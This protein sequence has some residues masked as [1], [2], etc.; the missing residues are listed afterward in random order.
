MVF[1]PLFVLGP[2]AQVLGRHLF[3]VLPFYMVNFLGLRHLEGVILV[4]LHGE[5]H[6][7]GQHDG[8]GEELWPEEAAPVGEERGEDGL[9]AV[10]GSHARG[11]KEH[12]RGLP[13]AERAAHPHL[14]AAGISG[15]CEQHH[16][17]HEVVRHHRGHHDV[18][19]GEEHQ[20]E[21]RGVDTADT[22]QL[23]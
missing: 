23:A 13:R 1:H 21:Q 6:H 7:E 9:G 18:S 8:H 20:Y 10:A 2:L 11:E 14:A 16:R 15:Q 5:Q 4:T 22:E 3:R 17:W 19:E 12:Q